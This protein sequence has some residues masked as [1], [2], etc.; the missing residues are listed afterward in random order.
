MRPTSERNVFPATEF[1]PESSQS[2][3][4]MQW[5]KKK[6]SLPHDT[7]VCGVP[8]YKSLLFSFSFSLFFSVNGIPCNEHSR[9]IAVASLHSWVLSVLH[10]GSCFAIFKVSFKPQITAGTSIRSS[11]REGAGVASR[12]ALWRI[13][14][15]F[16][17]TRWNTP[18]ISSL[19]KTASF[20]SPPRQ[21]YY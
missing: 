17:G 15:L 8:V 4:C 1:C 3:C 12:P 6:S 20:A 10:T 7:Q 9:R 19:A 14:N 18:L 11:H 13:Y 21:K 2:Q 5:I 16:H